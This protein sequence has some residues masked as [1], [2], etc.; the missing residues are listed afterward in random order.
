M[1]RYEIY[2]NAEELGVDDIKEIDYYI[3]LDLLKNSLPKKVKILDMFPY[4]KEVWS[5][6]KRNIYFINDGHMNERGQELISAFI[7]NNIDIP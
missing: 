7:V 1:D 4:L 2:F 5:T 3:E 6:D